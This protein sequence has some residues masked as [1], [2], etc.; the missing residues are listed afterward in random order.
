ME[1]MVQSHIVARGAVANLYR[2][3]GLVLPRMSA[4]PYAHK[5]LQKM[6]F[7]FMQSA[8]ERATLL[9][10]ANSVQQRGKAGARIS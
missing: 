1:C 8:A 9:N 6:L 3:E 5:C 4:G 10:A 7:C 2:Q